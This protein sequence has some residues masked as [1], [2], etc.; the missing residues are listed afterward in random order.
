M[1]VSRGLASVDVS[2]SRRGGSGVG[3]VEGVVGRVYVRG[4]GGGGGV[5]RAS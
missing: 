1:L 2:V 5:D 3:T 4:G